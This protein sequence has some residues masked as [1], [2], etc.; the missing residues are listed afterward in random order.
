MKNIYFPSY[1]SHELNISRELEVSTNG[2]YFNEKSKILFILNVERLYNPFLNISNDLFRERSNQFNSNIGMTEFIVLKSELE[3]QL[4]LG[5]KELG[6]S[7]IFLIPKSDKSDGKKSL[8]DVTTAG[9]RTVKL[10]KS[11]RIEFYEPCAEECETT[12]CPHIVSRIIL[13]KSKKLDLYPPTELLRS[14]DFYGP[15]LSKIK[16]L[17]VGKRIERLLI[18]VGSRRRNLLKRLIHKL[19]TIYQLGKIK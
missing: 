12:F 9:L 16:R 2:Y 10:G 18:P 15:R 19:F 14:K 17:V 8:N 1:D 3:I 13:E 4:L 6:E 7:K 11:L 5:M